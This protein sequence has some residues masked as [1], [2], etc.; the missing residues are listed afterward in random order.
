VVQPGFLQIVRVDW[1]TPA[2]LLEQIIV[3]EA[4]HEIRVE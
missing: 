1:H 3:H 2:Y 4:V